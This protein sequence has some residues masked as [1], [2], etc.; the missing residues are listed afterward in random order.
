LTVC[1]YL[2][3]ASAVQSFLLAMVMYSEVQKR[4]QIE[5]DAV[6]G[7]ERLLDLNHDAL[8]YINAI[9]KETLSNHPR[10]AHNTNLNVSV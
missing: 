4:A 10:Q 1:S 5:L 3:S 8:P 7:H 6:V 9:V 2:Q